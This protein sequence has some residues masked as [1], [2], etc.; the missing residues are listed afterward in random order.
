MTLN[1]LLQPK[2]KDGKNKK[3]ITNI[4]I[5][6]V[7]KIFNSN[8]NMIKNMY[9]AKYLSNSPHKNLEAP[10]S[11]TIMTTTKCMCV[12]V[13]VH[14]SMCLNVVLGSSPDTFSL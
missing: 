3:Q 12:C 8:N 7:H 13:G 9:T 14:V 2:N 6:I 4:V 1:L 10:L 5:K 11:R